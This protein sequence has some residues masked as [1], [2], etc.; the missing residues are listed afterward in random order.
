MN[1]MNSR[2]ERSGE[3]LGVESGVATVRLEAASGCSSCGSRGTCAAAGAARQIV[4]LPLARKLAPG[5]RVTVSMPESSVALAAL[6]GYLVPPLGLLVGA[7]AATLVLGGEFDS[8]TAA[9][10]GGALGLVGGLFI[11]RAMARISFGRRLLPSVC[12]PE[13]PSGDLP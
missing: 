3:V 11:A 6:I 13:T 1:E 9:V 10:L 4:H 2:A 12:H 5:D 7:V 8:D